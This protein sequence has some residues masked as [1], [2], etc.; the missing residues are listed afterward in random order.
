MGPQGLMVWMV[1]GGLGLGLTAEAAWGQ[2]VEEHN[3]DQPTAEQEQT[4]A[5]CRSLMCRRPGS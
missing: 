2:V 1:L 3:V 4:P 5:T